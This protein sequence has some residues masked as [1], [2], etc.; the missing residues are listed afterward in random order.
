MVYDA[1]DL[2][3]YVAKVG[4][5]RVKLAGLVFQERNCGIALSQNSPYREPINVALLE[6][7]ESSE[8]RTLYDKWFGVGAN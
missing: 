3:H 2:Q 1:P 5:G 6:L 7:T 8:Y 4:N